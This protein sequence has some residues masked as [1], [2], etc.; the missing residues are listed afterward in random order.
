MLQCRAAD[1]HRPFDINS[2]QTTPDLIVNTRG[3]IQRD[4]PRRV[5]NKIEPV[6]A[7]SDGC[8][9]VGPA[10]DVTFDGTPAAVACRDMKI[11]ASET[12][13]DH[14][15]NFGR[16]PCNDRTSEGG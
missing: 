5:D 12:D 2:K 10:C 13:Q 1:S 3:R 15:S 6:A 4:Q 16:E 14:L 9:Y 11:R 8:R 7:G